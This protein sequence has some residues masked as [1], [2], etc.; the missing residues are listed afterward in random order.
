MSHLR[1]VDEMEYHPLTEEL[2]AVLC[3][4]T[5][6][7]STEFFRLI[8]GYYFAKVASM[9]RCNIQTL[10]R[11][12]IPVNFYAVNL[13]TSGFGKGHSINIIEEHLIEEFREEFLGRTFPLVAE[14]NLAK[15]AAARA[16]RYQEDPDTE[17]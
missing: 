13:A 16:H 4:R 6:N 15:L 8:L 17:L 2:I 11:G 9:M 10:D 12:I 14:E 1:P 5:Q 3:Q 7:Y